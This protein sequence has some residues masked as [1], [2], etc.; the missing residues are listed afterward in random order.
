MSQHV[1]AQDRLVEM[2]G[3]L[4]VGEEAPIPFL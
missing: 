2:I 3:A 4:L 1:V